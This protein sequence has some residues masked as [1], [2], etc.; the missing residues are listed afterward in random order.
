MNGAFALS[1]TFTITYGRRLRMVL[2]GTAIPVFSSAGS[3]PCHCA[4][5]CTR[6]RAA[7][8]TGLSRQ[9]R[10]HRPPA[11]WCLPYHHRTARHHHRPG[12]RTGRWRNRVAR[13]CCRT[14][15]HQHPGRA[16]LTRTPPTTSPRPRKA[17]Q[18]IGRLRR[19]TA[20]RQRF[21]AC[22]HGATKGVDFRRRSNRLTALDWR[23]LDVI[24]CYITDVS[25]VYFA[26][27]LNF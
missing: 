9:R 16:R 22:L 19:I 23:N 2:I 14:P 15:R 13:R 18:A 17:P 20:G 25:P 6:Q 4:R 12:L 11:C 27:F 26:L 7:H 24:Y 10:G 5:D 21:A 8:R 1:D 3:N